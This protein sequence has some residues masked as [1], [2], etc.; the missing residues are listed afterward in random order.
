[1]SFPVIWGHLSLH[2][3]SPV[4][5]IPL[6][7][8]FYSV[9][10]LF[11]F[12]SQ[13]SWDSWMSLRRR[14]YVYSITKEALLQMLCSIYTCTYTFKPPSTAALYQQK[15]EV[16]LGRIPSVLELYS[17]QK[18]LNRFEDGGWDKFSCWWFLFIYLAP[19][20]NWFQHHIYIVAF[21]NQNPLS[22]VNLTWDNIAI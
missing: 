3:T 19:I 7:I 2:I 17:G 15:S 22:K 8:Q 21:S 13:S 5:I 12:S 6:L 20:L 4:T 1:M 9:V 16:V 14:R 11:I 10:V 18:L